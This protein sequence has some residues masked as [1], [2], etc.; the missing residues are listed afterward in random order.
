MRI[1]KHT[2]VAMAFGASLVML[3]G[4]K[5]QQ[6]DADGIRAGITHHLTALN[7]LNLNAMDMDIRN[8]SVQ[9]AE[10]RAEV[11]FRP[12]TGAPPDAGM[13][14]AYQLEK[15][16]SGWFVV[17]TEAVGGEITHPAAGGNPHTQPGQSEVHGDLPNFREILPGGQ[18]P[19]GALPAGHPPVPP[20]STASS[21]PT[22]KN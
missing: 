2:W 9:G 4:C 20:N 13:Q 14:V 17:K 7:T 22:T 1:T 8:V 21:G 5:K 15:R 10:A 19:S 3:P 16:D 18:P 11:T 6:S 12:K